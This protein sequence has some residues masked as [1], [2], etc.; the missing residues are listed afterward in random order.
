MDTVELSRLRALLFENST[1]IMNI[2]TMI[3]TAT[4]GTTLGEDRSV[5]LMKLI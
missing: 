5:V 3:V 4:S 1:D 2:D